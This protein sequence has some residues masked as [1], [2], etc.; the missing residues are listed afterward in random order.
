[1]ACS[2]SKLAL[3]ELQHRDTCSECTCCP[4]LGNHHRARGI[5]FR[6]AALHLLRESRESSAMA[7]Y[8]NQRDDML[9]GMDRECVAARPNPPKPAHPPASREAG[10][11]YFFL[12]PDTYALLLC[13]IAGSRRRLLPSTT[14]RWRRRR[15]SGLRPCWASRSPPAPSRRPSRAASPSASW[16][17][18][19]SLT[20]SAR[21]RR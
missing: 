18:R 11:A 15:A 5:G 14:R 7:V 10:R 3:Q 9:Y 17:A 21:P 4:K 8:V 16:S 13:L 1:M 6:R 20:S 12:R 19:S 2:R